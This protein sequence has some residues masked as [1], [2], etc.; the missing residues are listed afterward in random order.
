V[1]LSHNCVNVAHSAA[2]PHT[3]T[4]SS[5]CQYDKD[6]QHTEDTTSVL[7]KR[8]HC[9]HYKFV[10]SAQ[11]LSNVTHAGTLLR[12]IWEVI[13]GQESNLRFFVDSSVYAS[14]RI[15]S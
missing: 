7:N 2:H 1:T 4:W 8:Q 5:I 11:I 10:S 12:Y 14:N 9:L 3:H 6:L 15:E 13:P